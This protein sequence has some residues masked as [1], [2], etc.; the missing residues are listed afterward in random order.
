M[1][2]TAVFEKMAN[3]GW[4]GGRT[5]EANA[6]GTALDEARGNLREAVQLIIEANRLIQQT[7]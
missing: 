5:A 3:G 2:L 6:Q 4:P 7:V 1:E